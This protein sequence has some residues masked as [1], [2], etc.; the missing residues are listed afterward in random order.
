MQVNM[1]TNGVPVQ[2]GEPVS[3]ARRPLRSAEESDLRAA[4]ELQRALQGQATLRLE[5]VARGK[6]LV[7]DVLY[8][9]PELINA[10]ARL[11]AEKI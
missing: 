8:P 10:L 11:L 1:V 7:G 5:E 3:S 6:E 2:G 4:E 9:P